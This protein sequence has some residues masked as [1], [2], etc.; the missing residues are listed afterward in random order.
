MKHGLNIKCNQSIQHYIANIRNSN[1][2]NDSALMVLTPLDTKETQDICAKSGFMRP[3]YYIRTGETNVCETYSTLYNLQNIQYIIE[4]NDNFLYWFSMSTYT[5]LSTI[6]GSGLPNP[7][8]CGGGG[9]IF[10][11]S[12]TS[13]AF[14]K[15][16]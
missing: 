1:K 12:R 5:V 9:T 13:W 10:P 16:A 8:S 2:Y 4:E 6:A 11:C 7:N 14:R 3:S 15:K